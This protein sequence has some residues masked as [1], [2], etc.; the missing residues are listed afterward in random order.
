MDIFDFINNVLFFKKYNE[1]NCEDYK[2]YNSYLVN[3]WA[4]M[5]SVE[6]ANIIN[7]S[8]NKI[9]FLNNDDE[10]RYKFLLKVLPKSKYRKIE[11]IKKPTIEEKT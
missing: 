3:R 7:Q 1:L 9:G 4:S 6:D 8:V 10:L 5:N 2:K 11:Y